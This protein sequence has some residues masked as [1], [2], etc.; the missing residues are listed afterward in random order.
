MFALNKRRH[1]ACHKDPETQSSL[2]LLFINRWGFK[3]RWV[4]KRMREMGGDGGN[5]PIFK[6]IENTNKYEN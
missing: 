1:A 6:S 4:Y 5:V 2:I 3:N